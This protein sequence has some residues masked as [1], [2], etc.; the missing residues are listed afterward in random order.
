MLNAIASL[1]RARTYCACCHAWRHAGYKYL[2]LLTAAHCCSLLFTG[3]HC[4]LLLLT[5][6]HCRSLLPTVAHCC[7]LPQV[8]LCN[9]KKER[10]E[11]LL[12]A[13]GG[14]KTRWTENATH[15]AR[16][17]VKLTGEG[18]PLDG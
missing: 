12:A 17:Y 13:L 14:E 9:I 7:S 4:C 2:L 15:L 3:G 1:I 5:T 11:Q 6:V 16:V 18:R 10:A 8:E